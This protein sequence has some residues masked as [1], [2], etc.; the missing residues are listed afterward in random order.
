MAEPDPLGRIDGWPVTT[1][2]AAVIGAPS[3]G[4]GPRVLATHGRTGVV[5]PWASLTKLV[6]AL[7][8]LVAVERGQVGLDDPAGPEGATVRHLLAHAS[9]LP[10][11]AGGPASPPGRRRV[12]S[13]HGFE[14]LAAHL[15]ERAGRPFAAL[16]RAHV[17]APLGMDRTELAGSPARGCRGPL[18][19][20]AR[21]AGELL[22]PTLISERL[23]AEATRPAFGDLDGVLPGFGR[24]DPDT[25]GLGFE[26]RDGKQPHWTGR[27]NSPR[28]FGHFGRAG[29]F[30][31]VDPD[32]GL[33][34]AVLTDRPFGAWAGQAWP[35][36][37]DAVLAA[38]A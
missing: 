27:R 34:C 11:R 7:T 22:V 15:E 12:Y 3:T 30:L 37:S 35:A 23:H 9:G 36:L 38:Y 32:A 21:L 8:V 10:P 26:I 24:Q 5:L 16:A 14:V 28:T 31:W 13:S 33:A 17:L 25:W 29:G 6:T 4:G 1:A 19:D 18:D 20:L 2:A